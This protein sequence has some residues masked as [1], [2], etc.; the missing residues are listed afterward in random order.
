MVEVALGGGEVGVD[1]KAARG[2]QV[3][4]DRVAVADAVVAVDDVGQLAARRGAGVEDVAVG[5]RDAVSLRKAQ[6]LRPNGLLSARP[7]SSG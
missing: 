1:G 7:N 3:G 6:T 4:D 5:E 2:D